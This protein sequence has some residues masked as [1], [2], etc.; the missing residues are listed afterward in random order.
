MRGL[1]PGGDIGEE[2]GQFGRDAG[3]GIGGA[4]PL[5]VLGAALL[6]H[7]QPGA[8][9][10][11]QPGEGRGHHVAEHPRAERA[12]QHQQAD[13]ALRRGVALAG[14]R[15][16]GLAHRVA[17]DGGGGGGRHPGGG[18]VA[19]RQ[20]VGVA[21]QHPVGAAEHGVLL[22]QHHAGAAPQ[23]ARAQH[24]RHR[25]VAAETHQHRGPQPGQDAARLH[26]AAGERQRRPGG[27]RQTAPGDAG[28]GDH[29]A[30]PSREGGRGLATV[31][32]G[33]GARVGHQHDPPAAPQ[34]L[35]G[36][37]LGGEEMP[38]G[39]A[40]GDDDRG[41]DHG[42]AHS[43]SPLCRRRVSASS[44]PMPTATASAEEPP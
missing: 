2:G 32:G 34:Q 18:G 26:A 29:E 13:M 25:G 37:R 19:Q 3:L 4:H 33:G 6:H 16:D 40:G 24:R 36:E 39:A 35:G 31:H 9:R 27:P 41:N 11:R 44:M 20:H 43:K 23:R 17:G 12:A 1:Q 15:R 28:A 5:Q 8:Q 38:A 7:G 22:V 42:R 21:A 14:E 30:L 10:H